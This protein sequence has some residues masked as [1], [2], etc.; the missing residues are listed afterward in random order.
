MPARF[1]AFPLLEAPKKGR[2][3]GFISHAPARAWQSCVVPG[4]DFSRPFFEAF[5]RG[6]SER[7]GFLS[8]LLGPG[9]ESGYRR[10]STSDP[11]RTRPACRNRP[12]GHTM[13]S[14]FKNRKTLIG[15]LAGLAL[16]GGGTIAGLSAANA[17]T[18]PTAP[19]SQPAPET[20]KG[21]QQEPKLNG[22]I[23]VPE[24]AGEQSDTQESAQL[25]G[26]A[27]IDAKAAEAAAVAS[28]PGSSAL[29]SELGDENGFLV[30]EVTVKDGAGAISEVK[31]DAGNATVL[32]TEAADQADG[33]NGDQNE[34]ADASEAPDASDAPQTGSSPAK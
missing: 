8:V 4:E 27:T 24:T 19:V 18:T 15:A 33:Q 25:A 7:S 32:A 6:L 26:L 34:A 20:E 11:S 23:T 22:S 29:S 3:M 30:Y 17:S 12:K 10:R 13:N 31:I 21:E 1:Q 2:S 14:T 16:V 5:P 28:I 9:V